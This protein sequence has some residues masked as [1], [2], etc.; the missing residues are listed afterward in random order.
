MTTGSKLTLNLL[1]IGRTQ[2]G[3]S[4]S[5]NTLLGSID[6]ASCLSLGSVTTACSLGRS[7]HISSL[8][9]RNGNQLTVQVQV[10]DTPGFPHSSLRKEQVCQKVKSALA[11]HF[12][13]KGLHLALLVLRADVP[14]CEEDDEHTTQLVQVTALLHIDKPVAF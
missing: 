13:E 5:G 4:A 14:L 3:K 10:L 11:E 8:A 6:F 1:L 2:S 12:G 9:R 7:C